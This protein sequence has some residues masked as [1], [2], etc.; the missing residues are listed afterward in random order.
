[1]TTRTEESTSKFAD[2]TE[3]GL[4]LRLH[5]N[6]AGQGQTVIML[7]GGGPGA[8]GWSNFNRNF[9]AFVD[10]GYRV[11]LLDCPGFNKSDSIAISESRGLVNARAVKALMDKLG[12]DR[13]H[14]VG[15]SLGG[16]SSLSLALES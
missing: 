8:G 11:I 16:I 3:K 6:E 2:V 4:K 1:M 14:L 10:A 7:H 5:Y 15:N 12:I 13:A 9:D